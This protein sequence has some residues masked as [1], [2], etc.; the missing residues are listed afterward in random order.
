MSEINVNNENFESVVLNNDKYVLADFWAPW[1]GPC[2][3]L[4]PILEEI[5]EQF[6]KKIDIAKINVD[7]N[8]ELSMK[9]GISSIPTI[10]LFKNGQMLD[11][12]IGYKSKTDLI[13]HFKLN[14]L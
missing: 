5:A 14:N 7:N 2:M 1:C 3:M 13:E 10:I 12:S 11:K 8:D 6:D 9:Y 4:S